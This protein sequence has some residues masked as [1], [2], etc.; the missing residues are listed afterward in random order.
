MLLLALH[1]LGHGDHV[2]LDATFE[3][4]T[5]GHLSEPRKDPNWLY[6]LALLRELAHGFGRRDAAAAF[7][8]QLAPYA[9][10]VITT[11]MAWVCA[12]SASHYLG[13]LAMTLER[14]DDSI[15]HLEDALAV[16]AQLSARPLLAH[17]HRQLERALLERTD[18]ERRDHEQA[19]SHLEL[20]RSLYRELGM[21]AFARQTA[22][23]LGGAAPAPAPARRPRLPGGLTAREAE[24]L[25]LIAAGRSNREIA[26]ELVISFNTVIR[27]VTHILVKTGAANRAEAAVFAARHG[28]AG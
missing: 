2:A 7:Y 12:G 13:L 20:A 22:A 24:V 9:G 21:E 16:H 18:Q 14:W 6:R 10:H 28:L 3:R 27:H 23:L 17:T 5:V 19:R 1:E 8:Q 25:R 26:D 11:G 4:L 15:R